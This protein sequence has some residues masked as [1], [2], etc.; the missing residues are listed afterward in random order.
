MLHIISTYLYLLYTIATHFP[1]FRHYEQMQ[2]DQV[3]Y[4][5][6]LYMTFTQICFL[7]ID[8]GNDD[9]ASETVTTQYLNQW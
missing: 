6:C 5:S 8:L 3:G 7:S 1:V 4:L 9:L 2:T